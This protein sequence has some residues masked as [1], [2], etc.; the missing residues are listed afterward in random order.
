MSGYGFGPPL[1]DFIIPQH[2]RVPPECQIGK[3]GQQRAGAGKVLEKFEHF[4]WPLFE[5][6]PLTAFS[7]AAL[8]T[9]EPACRSLSEFELALALSLWRPLSHSPTLSLSEFAMC[10]RY[11]AS[12]KL[13]PACISTLPCGLPLS[14]DSVAFQRSTCCSNRLVLPAPAYHADCCISPSHFNRL[15][16]LFIFPYTFA[17]LFS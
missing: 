8:F 3:E 10:R 5:L 15:L 13:Q 12:W 16:F 11:S 9:V 7:R 2:H 1:G 14:R 17:S 6:A 4:S